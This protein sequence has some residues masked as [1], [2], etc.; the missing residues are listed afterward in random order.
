MYL[1]MP[2]IVAGTAVLLGSFSALLPLTLFA[3]VLHYR[4]VLPEK[5][6]MPQTSCEQYERYCRQVR[7]WI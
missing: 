2:L 7:R 4:F 3:L 1:G 5:A 6:M